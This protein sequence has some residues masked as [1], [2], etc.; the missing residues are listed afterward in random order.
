MTKLED[1]TAKAAAS[2]AAVET[3]KTDRDRAFHRN[4]HTIW[5]KLIRGLGEAEERAAARPA[6]PPPAAAKA[7]RREAR[8]VTLKGRP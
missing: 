3:A 4:A 6:P 1:Y 5:R 7:P 8:T 2:L